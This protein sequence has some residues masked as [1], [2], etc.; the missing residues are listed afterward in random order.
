MF[1]KSITLLGKNTFCNKKLRMNTSILK[2]AIIKSPKTRYSDTQVLLREFTGRSFA[3]DEAE[4]IWTKIVDHKWNV[5]EKL[6]RDI[7]FK[8]AAIDFVEN[9]YL[10]NRANEGSE[11]NK[12]S[13][14]NAV[15]S[16]FE[17]K[18]Q[19]LYFS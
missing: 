13:L 2:L 14:T 9:H 4:T 17:A 5:S 12:N 1:E 11:R 19:S 7:G 16:Y 18:G 15:I 3:R 8:V 10:L 6:Q